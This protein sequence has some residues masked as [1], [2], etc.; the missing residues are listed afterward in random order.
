[1]SFR[2]GRLRK[3][4]ER[5]AAEYTSSLKFDRE[6]L[7]AVV[8]V[9]AVHLKMLHRLGFVDEVT[10][11]SALETLKEL[12]NSSLEAIDPSLEDVHIYVEE[13]LMKRVPVAAGMLSF[14][15]SRND[16]VSAAIRIRARERC[17]RLIAASLDFV[18]GVLDV[19]ERDAATI[20]PV[21]THMQVAAPATYGFVL[22]YYASRVL[23]AVRSFFNALKEL[24]VSPLGAAAVAGTS[25]PLD[26]EWEAKE[27]AF[28]GLVENALEASSSRDFVIDVLSSILKLSLILSDFA[29]DFV[30]L[31][32]SGLELLDVPEE[33]SSTS[34]IMP[35]KKNP[36][37]P[38]IIRTKV[39]EVLAE[40]VRSTVIA[41][42]KFGGYNL[43]LQQITPS[44]WKAFDEIETTVRIAKTVVSLTKVRAERAIE[45]C[46]PPAGIVELANKLT[47]EKR[48]PF[49]K[50]HVLCGEIARL[51]EEGL[52]SDEELERVSKG[53]G[54]DL[55]IGR[56]ELLELIEPY[57]VVRSYVT[58][59]SSNP[60]MV[61]K[62]VKEL[63]RVLGEYRRKVDELEAKFLAVYEK[64]FEL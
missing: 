16:A 47:L 42:R 50:A 43:D 40:L 45:A 17:I 60:S 27:L 34:S 41:S 2:R 49:R 14:G 48:L 63:R 21:F 36:I 24:N 8:A 6:I 19:A 37:V 54:I 5:D 1:M 33:L 13:E 29:E 3:D 22:S 55:G 38:E 64:V 11:R 62:L 7:K 51:I 46:K 4:L 56:K 35:H 9:N 10:C 53:L 20:F 44:I 28:D 15:K 61:L 52:L 26:R 59:G 32:S 12:S 25:I 30:V 23:G 31:S 18:E 58:D 57:R 39:G